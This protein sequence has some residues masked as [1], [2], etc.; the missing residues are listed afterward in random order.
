MNLLIIN[1]PDSNYGDLAAHR[2]LTR[3]IKNVF[4]D[5]HLRILSLKMNSENCEKMN[6]TNSEYISLSGRGARFIFFAK[7][8]FLLKYF[9]FPVKFLWFFFSFYPDIKKTIGYVKWAD[10]VICA[11]G[12]ISMGTFQNWQHILFL[13]IAKTF[14]KKLAYYSR[15]WGPFTEKDFW[16]RV[17]KRASLALLKEFDFHSIRDSKTMKMADELRLNYIPAIDTVF[18]DQPRVEIPGEIGG[19]IGNS[20]YRIFVPNTLVWHRD[21]KSGDPEKIK[22][23]YLG[24]MR[25][26]L[27][28]YPNDKIIMLPQLYARRT[29]GDESFFRMLQQEM[30]DCRIFVVSDKYCSDVQQ[31]LISNSKLVIGARYHSIV[32]A[33]NNEVPF[34]SLSYEHKMNGL[35]EIL[36]AENRSVD[37]YD[38]KASDTTIDPVLARFEKALGENGCSIAEMRN[39]AHDIAQKCM[40]TFIAE[41]QNAK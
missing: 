14:G 3:Y 6:V 24:I 17:Y 18:L 2:S 34:I 40:D 1:Q 4:P 33:I 31:T 27:D 25:I 16:S 26:L 10:Y 30:N 35:L 9:H 32:F 36:D 5:A 22:S 37:I 12:G 39:K 38:L 23:F 11:H 28:R 7:V 41:L 8:I 21:Y 19:F 15:S 20:D 29:N 13:E